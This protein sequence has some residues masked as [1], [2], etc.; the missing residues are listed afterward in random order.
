MVEKSRPR[1]PDRVPQFRHSLIHPF[2][3]SPHKRESPLIHYAFVIP[4]HGRKGNKK[5][6]L[7]NEIDNIS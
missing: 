5:D 7:S 3:N 4:K 6:K 2:C 1:M